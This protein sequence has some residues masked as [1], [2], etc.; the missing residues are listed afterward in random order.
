MEEKLCPKCKRK[1]PVDR[2]SK[3]SRRKDG[4]QPYCKDCNKVYYD[5]HHD[6]ILAGRAK[7][8]RDTLYDRLT[9]QAEY[10]A[11]HRPSAIAAARFCNKGITAERYQ[12]MWDEQG[13]LCAICKKPETAMVHGTLKQLA[14][15]HDHSCCPGRKSCGK[16]FR[17]LLCS[18]CNVALGM[19]H[20]DIEV[21][22]NM[23]EYLKTSKRAWSR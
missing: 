17:K 22:E 19:V 23:I 4:H 9:W 16:C 6:T 21:L 12:E 10:R 7:Y 18:H 8:Y 13:G 15:D 2:F 14:A 5:E 1:L 3:D 20:D 11:E